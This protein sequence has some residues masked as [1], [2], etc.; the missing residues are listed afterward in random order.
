[1]STREY[2][3]LCTY[4]AGGMVHVEAETLDEAREKAVE[5]LASEGDNAFFEHSLQNFDWLHNKKTDNEYGE[6]ETMPG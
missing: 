2:K 6:A 3:I 5:R 4:E 1:M